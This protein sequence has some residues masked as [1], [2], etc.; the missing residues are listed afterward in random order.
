MEQSLP[1]SLP[2]SAGS[3]IFLGGSALPKIAPVRERF[4]ERAPE[5]LPPGARFGSGFDW[6]GGAL[7]RNYELDPLTT[8]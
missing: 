3:E 5:P 4:R 1:R 2:K 7:P 8:S 6:G